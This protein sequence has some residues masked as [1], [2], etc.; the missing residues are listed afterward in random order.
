MVRVAAIQG[1]AA[2]GQLLLATEGID[3]NATNEDGWTAIMWAAK[4]SHLGMMALLLSTKGID[5]NGAAHAAAENGMTAQL[6]EHGRAGEVQHG[7]DAGRRH[8]RGVGGRSD[9]ERWNTSCDGLRL[10]CTVERAADRPTRRNIC[11][12]VYNL[13]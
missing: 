6:M 2:V 8:E 10:P 1:H 9:N 12:H 11:I 7:V 3:V 13:P 5:V 4:H